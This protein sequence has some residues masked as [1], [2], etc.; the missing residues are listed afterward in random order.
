VIYL[1]FK[2]PGSEAPDGFY[3]AIIYAILLIVPASQ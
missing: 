3:F 2:P 1:S